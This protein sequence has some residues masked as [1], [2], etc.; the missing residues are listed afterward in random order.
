MKT[1]FCSIFLLLVFI[2][3]SQ[4]ILRTI[5]NSTT[6]EPVPFAT[7]KILHTIKGEVTDEKGAFIMP[8][9]NTDTIVISSAGYVQK[10]LVGSEAGSIIY[11]Q[12]KPVTLQEVVIKTKTFVRTLVLGNG[13]GS[14]N[15]KIHCSFNNPPKNN[16]CINWGSANY[17]EEFAEKISLPDSSLSYQIKKVFIPIRQYKHSRGLSPLLLRI[18]LTDTATGLPGEEIFTKTIP[19]AQHLL[20]KEKLVAD[21]ERYKIFLQNENAFFI[22]VGWPPGTSPTD[23][24]STLILKKVTMNNTYS[25]SLI[26]KDFGWFSF[27]VLQ[28]PTGFEFTVS[29]QYAVELAASK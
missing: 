29:T 26:K 22:S 2:S 27:G 24:M 28:N 7:V 11:L 12:P 19:V 5:L 16:H 3:H 14:I 23:G 15:K 21:L 18:Y 25:R 10:V 17:K 8:F 6:K 13:A 4:S 1:F 9:E 20:Y